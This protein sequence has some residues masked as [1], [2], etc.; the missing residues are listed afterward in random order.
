[1]ALTDIDSTIVTTLNTTTTDYTAGQEPWNKN[2]NGLLI[3]S[4]DTDVSTYQ[5]DWIKWHGYYRTIAEVKSMIDT[6]CRWL[7]GKEIKAKD[8]RTEEA[9]RKIKGNGKETFR[10]ILLNG[11]RTSK[12][13]GDAFVEIMR[14]KAQRLI[15]LQ[16]RNS[17]TIRIVTNSKG[18]IIKY[19]QVSDNG[20]ANYKANV[21]ATFK[22]EQ[23]FHIINN[24]IGDEIHG[25]PESESLQKLIKMR[26]QTMLDNQV[27]IHRYMK[28]TY[29]YEVD[30]DDITEM[31]SIKNK[32]DLAQTNF[33]NVVFPK[34]TLTKIEN[35]KTPQFSTIDPMPWLNFI[36]RNFQ[37]AGN[38]PDIIQGET[39]ESATSAADLNYV[40]FK[41]RII[42][43]Q[44]EFAED[45]ENQLGLKVE[46]EEPREI[47]L[48]SPETSK[49]N[50]T[51]EPKNGIKK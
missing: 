1:M 31:S 41:E 47:I 45:I 37:V 10:S 44:K 27:I 26:W 17:G 11:K 22:P 30:T 16:L 42:F 34:G 21:L 32:I 14:D 12:I 7:I 36:K 13:C 2:L 40:S 25:I 18:R 51:E 3:D 49:M 46:F 23:I 4:K 5:P 29:F 33:E 6:Y 50:N 35:V 9:I 38:V 28:P 48:V 15:N 39:R 24:K 43:E 20:S 8:T 19:E